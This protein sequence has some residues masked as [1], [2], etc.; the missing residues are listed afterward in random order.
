MLQRIESKLVLSVRQG[1][2]GE[3]VDF[4]N[5]RNFLFCVKQQYGVY[6][7][8]SAQYVNGKLLVIIPY[9]DAMKL[10]TSPTN[11]QLCW[12]DEYG[13]KKATLATPLCVGEL[14]REAGYE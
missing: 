12:T 2:N 13:N 14:L 3:L 4:S 6:M 11:G 7:E 5:A 1:R 8:F 10:T 9:K